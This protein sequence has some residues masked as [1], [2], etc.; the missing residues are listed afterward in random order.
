[1]TRL[2]TALTLGA[3]TLASAGIASASHHLWWE[4]TVFLGVAL[5]LTEGAARERHHRRTRQ[6]EIAERL[7]RL[8][9]GE[10]VI[11]PPQPCCQ[12]WQSSDGA[13]HGHDCTRPPA[14]RTSLSLAEQQALAEIT[15][16]YDEDT[17]A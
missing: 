9:R 14:A 12:F 1:M 3:A 5:F 4:T 8:A 13:I 2:E 6:R 17:A 10:A 11:E 15:A 16:H 7:E